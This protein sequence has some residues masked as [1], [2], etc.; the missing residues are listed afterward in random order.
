MELLVTAPIR[1]N[2]S[3]ETSQSAYKT[4]EFYNY[5]EE[6][7]KL[8]FSD[9]NID[10][11]IMYKKN[12][13]KNCSYDDKEKT[14]LSFFG[15][16]IDFVSSSILE[17]MDDIFIS[18]YFQNI[19]KSEIKVFDNTIAIIDLR[20]KLSEIKEYS[21]FTD[22]CEN[23]IKLLI[24]NILSKISL[25]IDDFLSQLKK[26]DKNNILEKEN[27]SNEYDDFLD[28]HKEN[29]NLEIMWAS[30]ALKYQNNDEKSLDLID[31]WLKGAI[32]KDEIK[33]IKNNNDSYSL[34]WLK[35]VFRENNNDIE[36][37]WDTMF[38]AQYIYSVIDVIVHNLK[39]IINESYTMNKRKKYLFL[40]LFKK[41]KIILVNQQ[42]EMIS[43]TAY[44]HITEYK[45]MKKFLQRDQLSV[46]NN[47]LEAWT[48]DDISKNTEELLS[49]AKDRAELIYNKI[50]TQN[51]FYTDILLTF[52]GFFAIIDLVLNFS[53]Y[54]RE[55]T[56][57]AMISSRGEDG[58]SFL[59][60][61]SSIPI[62]LFIGSGF[63]LSV[64]LLII[65]FI[66]RKKILP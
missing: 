52:I 45:D 22:N 4:I 3:L 54:S 30:C 43:A 1:F 41:N 15:I 25:S 50:A 65:Y 35:Y 47:I 16:K 24:E 66:Y 2:F 19:V 10:K 9:D 7:K 46:L 32:S 23:K 56:A 63:I 26:L 57:D 11:I 37:L 17:K 38:L 18:K 8:N 36:D 39:L 40:N 44:L 48:F 29:R 49:T 42:L 5:L 53:Q 64:G 51:N 13:N 14:N 62:D 58:Q 34:K 55:Y 59:F 21:D 33:L 12:K 27:L 28:F 61:L 60:Y 6:I 20:I 31:F